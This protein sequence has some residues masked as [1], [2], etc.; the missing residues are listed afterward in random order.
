ML[1]NEI[2]T[3]PVNTDKTTIVCVCGGNT[4]VSKD[5][6]AARSKARNYNS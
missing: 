3:Y 2:V 5:D 6:G 1:Q 4:F